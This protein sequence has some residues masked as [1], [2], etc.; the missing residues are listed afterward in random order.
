MS[1]KGPDHRLMPKLFKGGEKKKELGIQCTHSTY[2]CSLHLSSLY[3]HLMQMTSHISFTF[4]LI[5]T[6]I[7]NFI[8]RGQLSGCWLPASLNAAVLPA[9]NLLYWYLHVVHVHATNH[10][11]T[12]LIVG[13]GLLRPILL[14]K[15]CDKISMR[16]SWS[17]SELVMTSFLSLAAITP[18][19]SSE[20]RRRVCSLLRL[21]N[22]WTCG[23]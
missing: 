18:R 19:W 14:C 15:T 13:E 7:V 8:R 10:R 23:K 9:G 16:S 21:L 17:C 3:L 1:T 2:Y 12:I 20:V 5:W 22:E 4:L 11:H 6:T